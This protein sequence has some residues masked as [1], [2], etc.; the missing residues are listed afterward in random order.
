MIDLSPQRR[1]APAGNNRRWRL[2]LRGDHRRGRTEAGKR[3]G[4]REKQANST[5]GISRI[6]GQWSKRDEKN[7]VSGVVVSEA[8]EKEERSR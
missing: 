8:E 7:E 1:S 4:D 3:R 5:S 2:Q 6:S